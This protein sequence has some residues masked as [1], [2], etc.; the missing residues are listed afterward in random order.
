M[1]KN[2]SNVK[3]LILKQGVRACMALILIG[4]L[5]GCSSDSGGEIKSTDPTYTGLTGQATITAQNAEELSKGAIGTKFISDL[6]DTD[7]LLPLKLSSKIAG[8]DDSMAKALTKSSFDIIEDL[9]GGIF[10]GDLLPDSIFDFIDWDTF[11]NTS[12]TYTETVTTPDNKTFTVT[13]VFVNAV[14]TSNDQYL[15]VETFNGTGIEV[16]TY[17]Y[18]DGVFTWTDETAAEKLEAIKGNGYETVSKTLTCQGFTHQG[19]RSWSPDVDSFN[20]ATGLYNTYYETQEYVYTLNGQYSFSEDGE[21]PS[22]KAIVSYSDW[23]TTSQFKGS[24]TL[25][26]HYTDSFND[27]ERETV[28]SLKN[29]ELSKSVLCYEKEEETD[30]VSTEYWNGIGVKLPFFHVPEGDLE[31]SLKGDLSFTSESSEDGDSGEMS[32]KFGNSGGNVLT[33][34]K[35]GLESLTDNQD[36]HQELDMSVSITGSADM[37]YSY[38]DPVAAKGMPFS[39]TV[40]LLSGA[41]SVEQKSVED[42]DFS[43]VNLIQHTAYTESGSSIF[44]V[45]GSVKFSMDDETF[46]FSGAMSAEQKYSVEEN[47]GETISDTETLS[48][49]LDNTRLASA[50]FDATFHG[51]LTSDTDNTDDEGLRTTIINLLFKDG[52]KNKTY[53]YSDYTLTSEEI[54]TKSEVSYSFTMTGVTGRFYHPNFGY[55]DVTT[56]SPFDLISMKS[57]LKMLAMIMDDPNVLYP[58]EGTLVISGANDSAAKIEVLAGDSFDTSGY[59]ITAD[60]NGDGTFEI[61]PMENSWPN[62]ENILDNFWLV[63]LLGGFAS[64]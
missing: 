48:I 19:T 46:S 11:P 33:I 22:T 21:S 43:E 15:R 58:T 45:S 36:E 52:I 14:Q 55:V 39:L 5:Y 16:L 63:E 2:V 37:T 62:L 3:K 31:V 32:I 30:G 41:F 34:H 27:K 59:T 23:E 49:I 20:E 25:S 60:A 42:T 47:D 24:L 9:Y 50:A 18:P 44:A 64:R 54:R 51:T 57:P 6:D 61:G 17:N 26:D 29:G 40:T 8:S 56:P 35:K 13:H 4:I 7:D 1:K 38:S 12:G 28:L 53:K 10:Q